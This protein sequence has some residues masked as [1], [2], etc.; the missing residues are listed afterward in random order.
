MLLVQIAIDAI[1]GNGLLENT[2]ECDCG[3]KEVL[4]KI[5]LK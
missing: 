1:C 5:I 4:N 3:T 2:E